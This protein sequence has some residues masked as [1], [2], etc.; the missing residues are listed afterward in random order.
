MSPH[1]VVRIYL[2]RVWRKEKQRNPSFQFLK[3]LVNFLGPMDLMTI[4]DQKYPLFYT[5]L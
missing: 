1:P 4:H 2:W 3:D 5:L